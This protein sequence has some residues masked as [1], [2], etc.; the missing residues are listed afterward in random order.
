MI[1]SEF[2]RGRALKIVI[3]IILIISLANTYTVRSFH[4]G[5]VL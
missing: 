4:K 2:C 1:M 3:G 5:G